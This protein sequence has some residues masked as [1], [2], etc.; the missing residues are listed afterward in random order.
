[1]SSSIDKYIIIKFSIVSNLYPCH[2]YKFI[3]ENCSSKITIMSSWAPARKSS[4][5]SSILKKSMD[6]SLM[7]AYKS[8]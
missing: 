2:P 6:T 7:T 8:K 5:E 3:T 4:P 1:M